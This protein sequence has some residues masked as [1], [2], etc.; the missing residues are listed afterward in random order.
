MRERNECS[1]F[2]TFK[3]YHNLHMSMLLPNK[4]CSCKYFNICKIKVMHNIQLS[5]LGSCYFINKKEN[6]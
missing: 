2:E 3:Y 1:Y 5:M 6:I 4:C